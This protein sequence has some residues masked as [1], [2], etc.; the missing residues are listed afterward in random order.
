MNNLGVLRTVRSEFGKAI[1]KNYE[2]GRIKVSRHKF[3]QHE[4]REDGIVNTLDTVQKDNMLAVKVKEATKTGYAICRG[5][6]TPS[7][8][9]RSQAKLEEEESG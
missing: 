7:T 3:L 2:A 4:I 6:A 9:Q 5:G 8:S 1:R